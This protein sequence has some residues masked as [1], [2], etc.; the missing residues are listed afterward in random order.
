MNGD[1]NSMFTGYSDG[2]IK[3]EAETR[4]Y[5]LVC[6]KGRAPTSMYRGDAERDVMDV[7][8]AMKRDYRIDPDRV[9]LMGHSMGGYGTW[10]VAISHPEAFTAI[11]PIS[12]GGQA[13]GLSKIRHIPELV[14]H[15]D[16]D[17]TVNVS[18]SRKMVA[19]AKQLGIEVEYIEVPGG[20]HSSVVAPHFKDVFDWFDAHKQKRGQ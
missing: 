4:G 14:V 20:D 11:A 13:E 16:N 1:E 15:G 19:A 2:L 18:E 3:Q 12:G 5:V 8:A 17:P 10:S 7:L 9:Y 6:P